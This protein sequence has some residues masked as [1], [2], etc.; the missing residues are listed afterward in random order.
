[1]ELQN[2]K[3]ELPD[4]LAERE[5]VLTTWPTGKDV[6]FA[7]GVKYQE[8]LPEHKRFAAVLK[9][10]DQ[11]GK[12]LSQPRAGVALVDEHIA[13]LQGLQTACDLLPSTIDAYTRLNRYDEAAK[14]IAKSREAG[15]SLLNGF[16]AVNHGLAEC[17]RVVEAVDK[18]VQVR[19]GTPD[20]RLLAEI[21]LA[22]GFSAYEGGGIS[23]NI[24]Y[25]KKVSLER[26]IRD[27]QY[28]DR[29][30]G[31]YEEH[32]IRIN[33]EPFGPLSG[34]LVPPFMS[35][36]VAIIEGLLAL[37]QGVRSITVGYG[38]VGNIVQDIAA[39]R[40]LRALADEYFRAAGFDDFELTTVFHQW[41][42]GFP[43]NEAMAF[44][45]I[46]W[47]GAIAGM[48][49]A[50]KVIVKT[51][52]EAR[53]IPTME[54]N[55]QGLNATRQIL[56]MVQD[57]VFPASDAL[58]FEVEL[59]KRE[60]RAVMSKVFELGEGD[61]AVGTVRAFEA[62]VLDVP[63]APAACNAGKLLPVRDNHG[64]VRVFEAGQ[65]PL[66]ED[67]LTLHRDLIAERARAEGREPSFQMV[68][69]DIYAISKSTLI[70][71]PAK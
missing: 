38:Q 5:Q 53:G 65:V 2:K 14:G 55:R 50:T 58:A 66:P 51:P 45:V 7:D 47:G 15:T 21:T 11:E 8:S 24:P 68:V 71:R 18:P 62:G 12:T 57:Q 61:I 67:V 44:S 64:A 41:M 25:A 36:A 17:R 10:A 32:G 4:F 13:L 35:H 28:C 34:T 30:V 46:S 1:M 6:K 33:R 29:L 69:D 31:L 27:W 54:A 19:H 60:V 22:G 43:E 40:S 49:G 26:S 39:I 70:G 48:S 52:H 37:E 63:F 20:A 42:G 59:I 3:I 56:N 23:Y 16:P 9:K